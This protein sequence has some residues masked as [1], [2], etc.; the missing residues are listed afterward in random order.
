MNGANPEAGDWKACGMATEIILIRHGETVWNEQSRWQG[1]RDSDLTQ[2]GL[3]QARAL[4]E[5]L[6]AARFDALYSSD[7]GRAWR[8]AEAIAGRT[9]HRVEREPGL[10]ERALGVFEGLTIGEIRERYPAEHERFS[11]RD[12]DHVIPGGESVRGKHDRAVRCIESIASRHPQQRVVAVTHG[13]ILDALFR[14]S[15]NLSLAQPRT[16]VLYN[17]SLNNFLFEDGRWKLGTWGDVAH[18]QRAG[19]LD[20]Y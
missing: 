19:T 1:H 2:A 15:L 11:A 14:H 12:P 3:A 6:A 9:G 17:A 4:A 13:G 8:T 10:R 20:D 16:W 7:L 5:R 18:L